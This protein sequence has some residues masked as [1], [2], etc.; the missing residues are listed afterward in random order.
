MFASVAIAAP[1]ELDKFQL[2]GNSD[3]NPLS[4]RT[5]DEFVFTIDC[6]HGG[7]SD[8]GE[9]VVRWERSGD[10]GVRVTGTV[11][12]SSL[13][14]RRRDKFTRPGFV[15]YRAELQ[16]KKG[17]P[18]I[19]NKRRL[20]FNGGAG[21]DVRSLRPA[22]TEPED[23]DA[24]WDARKKELDAIPVKYTLKEVPNCSS[25]K[26]KVYSVR[27]DCAGSRPVTGYLRLPVDAAEKS[28]PARVCFL[29]YSVDPKHYQ[30]PPEAEGKNEIWFKINAHGYDLGRDENYC[31]DFLE[32]VKSNG[33]NYAFDPIQNRD[34]MRA[35]FMGMV[36]RVMRSLQ[37]VK[38]L[39]AWDGKNLIV[40]GG[41]Q[42]GLQVLWAAGLDPDVSLAIPWVPWCCDM[43][44]HAK[45]G[46][47]DGWRPEYTPALDYF[48]AAFHARRV[49][50]P[51]R[52]V[53][54]GLGDYIC[55]PSGVMAMFNSLAGPAEM[56]FIQGATHSPIVPEGAPRF[57]LK[58]D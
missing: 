9:Y 3:A 40:E 22:A 34:P 8:S 50:C 43:A 32:S 5:G 57:I 53:R 44:G 37:F 2:V 4:Y 51:T 17:R 15:R 28:L 11:P 41:S 52:I 12:L 46:R 42:G 27:V 36:M 19:W 45:G 58:K 33:K 13:P 6:K 56:V 49:K 14:F 38:S 10:D 7:D 29:G 31:R 35:Y 1:L 25:D 18:V 39:P 23:F 55:P 30:R 54:A 26:F 21:A 24:F 16:D 48:D 47:L 20:S